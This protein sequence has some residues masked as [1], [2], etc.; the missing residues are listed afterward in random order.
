MSFVNGTFFY[1]AKCP[2]RSFL[3][4][5]DCE[6]FF[7][8]VSSAK[9]FAFFFLRQ[10]ICEFIRNLSSLELSEQI[11]RNLYNGKIFRWHYVFYVVFVHQFFWNLSCGI[12]CEL[13]E[14]LLYVMCLSPHLSCR[15]IASHISIPH[16]L[17][18]R[19]LFLKW[20]WR[21]FV[22]CLFSLWTKLRGTL[23][24]TRRCQ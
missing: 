21:C 7:T 14:I 8:M 11:F 19:V 24:T 15:K 3:E 5:C 4:F 2:T 6:I 17:N 1:F 22:M 23:C 13:F 9:S 18:I 10:S 16:I 20:S 12:G